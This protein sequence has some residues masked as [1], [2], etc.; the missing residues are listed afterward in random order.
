MRQNFTILNQGAALERPTFPINPLLFRVPLPCLAAILDCCAMRRISRVLQETFL[1]DHLLKKDFPPQSSTIQRIRHPPLR[2]CVEYVN[3]F[4][5]ISKVEVVCWIKLV[6]PILTLV[7]WIIREFR[8]RKCILEIS[9][10]CGISKL[11]SQL[12]EWG[13]YKNSR[14][15]E[16]YALHKRSWDSK[17]N[18]RSLWH[19]NR[20]WGVLIFLT[21]MLRLHSKSFS[22]RRY[23]SGKE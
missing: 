19:R 4:N 20:L 15:S 16:H 2:N 3:P 1:N 11:E 9:W 17:I 6:E 8:F 7:W 5:T 21:S 13:M 23:T 10:L 14:P 12:Q 22:T 18:R